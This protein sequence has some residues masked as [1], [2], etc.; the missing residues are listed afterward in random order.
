[1]F[2]SC[3]ATKNEKI[4]QEYDS[5]NKALTEFGQEYYYNY[6]DSY[7]DNEEKPSRFQGKFFDLFRKKPEEKLTREEQKVTVYIYN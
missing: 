6:H 5:I 1:M 3:K 2:S 7:S 4:Y